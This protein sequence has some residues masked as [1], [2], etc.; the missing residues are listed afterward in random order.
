MI[1]KINKEIA[2]IDQQLDNIEAQ[3]K[4]HKKRQAELEAL[5]AKNSAMMDGVVICPKCE[6]KFFVGNEVSVEEIRKNLIGFRT[7][8][9]ESKSKVEK[10]NEEFDSIDEKAETKSEEADE[11]NKKNQSSQYRTQ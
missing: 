9:E 7:E 11:I 1:E 3:V 6:H 10:L 2:K 4:T 8:M 5:I